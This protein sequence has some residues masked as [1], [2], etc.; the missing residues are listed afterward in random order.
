M[1]H[2]R[3]L[4]SGLFHFAWFGSYH[5]PSKNE[6][7]FLSEHFLN[8]K[9]IK[10]SSS[11]YKPPTYLLYTASPDISYFLGSADSAIELC[12]RSITCP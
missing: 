11:N 9:A 5:E 2:S 6:I 3:S 12:T 8:L 10:S 4:A 1:N 7:H